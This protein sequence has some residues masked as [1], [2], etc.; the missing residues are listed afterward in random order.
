MFDDEDESLGGVG[1]LVAPSFTTALPVSLANR[2]AM[3][4]APRLLTLYA[5]KPMFVAAW[6]ELSARRPASVPY[7]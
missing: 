7:L 1:V 2:L 6:I 4:L 3:A 5:A